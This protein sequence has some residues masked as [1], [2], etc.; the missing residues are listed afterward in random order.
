MAY[1]ICWL[2]VLNCIL[3]AVVDQRE[4]RACLLLHVAF[5]LSLPSGGI[6]FQEHSIPDL[7]GS[8]S[9]GL[10]CKKIHYPIVN[11]IFLL[12]LTYGMDKICEMLME[13]GFPR[14]FNDSIYVSPSK[15][16]RVNFLFP[17]YLIL[18]VALGRS[19][20]VRTML[21][22][23]ASPNRS[24]LGLTPLLLAP[25]RIHP[26]AS[27]AIVK[28]LLAAGADPHHSIGQRSL[29]HLEKMAATGCGTETDISAAV[30]ISKAQ[31]ARIY[32]LDIAATA[33]NCDLVIA[34]LQGLASGGNPTESVRSCGLCL[35]TQSD[36]DITIRL[37]KA[38]AD[39]EQRDAEGNTPLHWAAKRGKTDI[40]AVLLHAGA[41]IDAV[42]HRGWYSLKRGVGRMN[43]FFLIG[44]PYMK[45]PKGATVKLFNS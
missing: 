32:P 36:L 44:Q 33:E 31:I 29:R 18:A 30:P 26:K 19:F 23:G 27:V 12:G 37:V 13:A 8:L 4:I 21:N 10:I 24:W 43:L 1:I 28:A 45:H 15:T 6:S 16:F 5:G 20:V 35:L 40:I 22:K 38:G 7:A 41:D 14:N 3:L 17:S 39:V 9:A 25:C 34:L 2:D 42:N 11:R